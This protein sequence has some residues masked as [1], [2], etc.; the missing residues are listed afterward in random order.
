[1]AATT[2]TRLAPDSDSGPVD[3]P[4][5]L[6][7]PLQALQRCSSASYEL[8]RLLG[9]PVVAPAAPAAAGDPTLASRAARLLRLAHGAPAFARGVRLLALTAAGPQRSPVATSAPWPAQRRV[10]MNITRYPAGTNPSFGQV[11]RLAGPIP[12]TH[13]AG[14]STS[15][16]EDASAAVFG[17][18]P[19]TAILHRLMLV[20]VEERPAA[21]TAETFC[22]G[23][24]TARRRDRAR[25]PAAPARP[26]EAD[27]CGTPAPIAGAERR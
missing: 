18:Q 17:C 12:A 23:V 10:P 20:T 11:V 22:A 9:T 26:A 7:V 6:P 14:R 5:G 15:A 21:V 1:M 27:R 13:R 24:G 25:A 4:V 2:Q 8:Q 3:P 19:G 16:A